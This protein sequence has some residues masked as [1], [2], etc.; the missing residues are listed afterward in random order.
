PLRHRD[1]IHATEFSADG[2]YLA[3]AS[4]DGAARVWDVETGTAAS[5]IF[6]HGKPVRF[7]AFSPDGRRLLTGGDDHHARVWD[8]A[9][10][11]RPVAEL[12]THARLLAARQLDHRGVPIP[13]T[14]AEE[15]DLFEKWQAKQP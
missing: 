9:P 8:L 11:A 2:R 10:D 12:L 5:P 14:P 1:F 4:H 15:T 6:E 13:L 3:T 7:A